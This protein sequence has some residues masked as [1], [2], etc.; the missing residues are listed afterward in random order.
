MQ[1][2]NFVLVATPLRPRRYARP[3]LPIWARIDGSVEGTGSQRP[4]WPVE[5]NVESRRWDWRRDLRDEPVMPVPAH[6]AGGSTEMA[7]KNTAV[8][9]SS[10]EIGCA[11]RSHPS[12]RQNNMAL[13]LPSAF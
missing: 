13:A 6:R 12:R 1:H 4:Y 8:T 11:A 3:S 2:C 7:M 9:T 10:P 5:Q